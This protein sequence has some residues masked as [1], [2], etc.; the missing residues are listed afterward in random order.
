MVPTDIVLETCT[1]DKQHGCA[2]SPDST[3]G[4]PKHLKAS[5]WAETSPNSLEFTGYSRQNLN[6]R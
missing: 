6:I 2:K 5:F 1:S 3:W 4:I